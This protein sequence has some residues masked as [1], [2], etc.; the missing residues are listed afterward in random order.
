M[1]RNRAALALATTAASAALLAPALPASAA[2]TKGLQD[3]EMT[4]NQPALTPAFLTAAQEAK[5]GLV[6]FNTR[7]DGQSSVPDAGQVAAIKA[8]AAKAAAAGIGAIEVAPNISGDASFNPKGKGKGPKASEKISETAY[9]AYIRALATALKDVPVARFYSAINEPNWYRHIPQRGGAILYRRLHNIAY[10]EIKAT[11]PGAKVLF[12]ELLPYARPK[13]KSYPHGQSADPGAFV[14]EALGLTS[15][16]KGKGRTASYTVKADGVSLHTYDF[17]A[18]PSRKTKT[19]GRDA[20]VHANLDW[21]KADLKKVAKTKRLSSTAAGRIY[22]TEF[23]YKTS[24]SDKLSTSKANSYLKK[25]W[26][27][28]K[29]QKV[30]SFLWYQLRD[31]VSTEELWQSGLQTRDGG[32]RSTWTTFKGLR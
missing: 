2:V 27:V 10:E 32:V 4:V 26:T 13:S 17:K 7:W 21:A 15:S 11:D 14:R 5:V 16:W 29:K 6:R 12:G 20:W 31:P 25:A 19:R 28:A 23:A 3:Q 22:L 9:R 24:G 30:R 18:D 8:F 1:T